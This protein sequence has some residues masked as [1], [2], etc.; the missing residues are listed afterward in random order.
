MEIFLYFKLFC[1]IRLKYFGLKYMDTL[2]SFGLYRI[3]EIEIYFI[4]LS[5]IRKKRHKEVN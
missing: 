1:S 5:I 3:G 4:S 2:R